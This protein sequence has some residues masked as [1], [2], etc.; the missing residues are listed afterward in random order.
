MLN[1]PVNEMPVQKEQKVPE[2]LEFARRMSE[3]G[4][5][6]LLVLDRRTAQEVMTEKR[7]ELLE[8]IQDEEPDSVRGL[9]RRVERDPAQV[10]RDLD[11]L[12]RNGIIE[13]DEQ[14]DR[15][16]PVL[17]HENVFVKP[18]L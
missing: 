14:G 5:S 9:A 16:V 10:S 1:L 13:F 2:E 15:K 7:T 3:A 4:Y 8:E 18:I 12:F 6:D 17:A 11:T